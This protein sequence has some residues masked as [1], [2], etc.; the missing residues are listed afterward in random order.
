MKTIRLT[1]AQAMVRFLAAQKAEIDGRKERLFEGVFVIF[2]HG[3][4]AG[5]GEA[6]YAERD[7]LPTYRAHNE[8]ATAHAAIAYAKAHFRRRMARGRHRRCRARRG[9]P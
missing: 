5:V 1:A 3:N 4:V 2:G 7:V 8:Q 9:L 6:L